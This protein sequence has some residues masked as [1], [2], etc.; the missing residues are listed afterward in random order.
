MFFDTWSQIGRVVVAGAS[1]YVA[2]VTIVRLSGKRTLA[3]LNAFDL[4]V[5]IALGSTLATIALSSD[6]A[7]LEGVAAFASFVALQ[8][9]VAWLS[10]RWSAVRR[11]VRSE[12]VVLLRDGEFDERAMATE[13][14]TR[15]EVRQSVR[16]SGV[17]GLELVAAVVLETDGTLS[18]VTSQQAGSRSALGSMAPSPS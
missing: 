18:V 9:V 2:L 4:V 7:I 14:V 11:A 1:A 8:F 3:K 17:G 16:S 5:T 12:P 13:R 10:T 6:V 15:D